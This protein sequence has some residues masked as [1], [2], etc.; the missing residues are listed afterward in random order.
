[1]LL[2]NLCL[3]EHLVTSPV[4][5]RFS[6][7]F[8]S[9]LQDTSSSLIPFNL[10]LPPLCKMVKFM[11]LAHNKTKSLKSK[12]NQQQQ[13]HRKCKVNLHSQILL[14]Q[15]VPQIPNFPD[16]LS[17]NSLLRLAIYSEDLVFFSCVAFSSCLSKKRVHVWFF[18]PCQLD[19]Q[20]KWWAYEEAIFERSTTVARL[21]IA[22]TFRP[23]VHSFHFIFY[24]IRGKITECWLAE[25]EGIFS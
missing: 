12:N 21:L 23:K 2:S 16:Y 22:R 11:I 9:S 24:H 6:F 19:T 10:L 7:E 3:G 13:L 15:V 1:M 5:G 25:T 18:I 4:R 17:R 20:N 14:V 8:V